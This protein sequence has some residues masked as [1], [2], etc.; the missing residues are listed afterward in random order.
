MPERP[1]LRHRLDR[2]PQAGDAAAAER[3][4]GVTSRAWSAWP[5]AACAFGP[6]SRRR[7][8][9][10]RRLPG[11]EG[12]LPSA[13]QPRRPV[14]YGGRR[15][16][17][18][19]NQANDR[20]LK[21]GGGGSREADR[22]Q[23]RQHQSGDLDQFRPGRSRPRVRRARRRVAP[24]PRSARRRHPAADRPLADGGLTNDEIAARVGCSP[25]RGQQAA[26]IR[27]RWGRCDD[28]AGNLLSPAEGPPGA[29]HR[30][31]DRFES[32]AG[33]ASRPDRGPRGGHGGRPANLLRGPR[34]WW[35]SPRARRGLDPSG[36]QA[37][38]Q[39][40]GARRG[41]FAEVAAA[42]SWQGQAG[43]GSRS[44]DRTR[45]PR[46][47]LRGARPRLQPQS[48]A[49]EIRPSWPCA[50]NRAGSCS[51]RSYRPARTPGIVPAYGFRSDASGRPCTP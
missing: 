6:A 38:S 9:T 29:D 11:I 23:R 8:K 28:R 32:A 35:R 45:W 34:N 24:A 22:P 2:Q 49:K 18:A 16:R 33:P 17:K 41:I 7:K 44:F 14:K 30:G 42:Q 47:G 37:R 19:I 1:R 13:R 4:W 31:V 21:R 3:L 39:A 12:T 26:V 20:R 5:G 10:W 25:G 27:A 50:R 51:R 43:R 46:P 48:R 15:A 40:R 36:Y